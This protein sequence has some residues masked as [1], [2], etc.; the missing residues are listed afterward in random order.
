MS[1]QVVLE[2]KDIVKDF[3]GLKAVN[4]VDFSISKGE[5]LAIIG[6]SGSG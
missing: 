1:G 5:T 2:M 3:S 4:C 6:P